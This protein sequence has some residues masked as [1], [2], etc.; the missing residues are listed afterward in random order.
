MKDTLTQTLKYIGL[1]TAF[2]LMHGCRKNDADPTIPPI[3][4]TQEQITTVLFNGFSELNPNDTSK[5]F[6]CTWEDTDGAGGSLPRIDTLKLDSG[7]R[8]TVTL[9]LLDKTKTP[10]DTISQEIEERKN[11]HQFFY[12]PDHSIVDKLAVYITDFDDNNPPLPVGL[13]LTFDTR[14]QASPAMGNLRVVLSHYDGIPKSTAPSPDTDLD[15]FFPVQ[16]H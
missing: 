5:Y 13:R 14:N 3:T 10:W 11:T 15:I 2:V 7:L 12:T 16:L 6:S 4:N 9:L 1:A 8:Y